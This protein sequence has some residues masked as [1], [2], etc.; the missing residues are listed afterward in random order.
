MRRGLSAV[1][2][3]ALAALRQCPRGEIAWRIAAPRMTGA[4]QRALMA[5]GWVSSEPTPFGRLYALTDL[6]RVILDA[7]SPPEPRP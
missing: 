6:G 2:K 3:Q 1:Q 4:T 7:A 5:R